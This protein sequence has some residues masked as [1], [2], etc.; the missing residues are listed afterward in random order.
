MILCKKRRLLQP[1]GN[2][3]D[4]KKKPEGYFTTGEFAKLCKVKKQTLFHYDHIGILK[5]ELIGENGY[6]YYSI[7][8]FD[9]YNTIAMLKELDMPLSRIRDFL[10]SRSPASFLS[11]L[12]AQDRLIDEKIAELQWLRSFV[13]G[14]EKITEEG[15]SA[16]HGEIRL[17]HRPKEYYIFTKYS[18]S[19]DDVD[20]Y[21]A[22]ADHVAHCHQNQIY[23]P[24]LTGGL[25]DA[26]GG[27]DD[28]DY[29]YSYLYTKLNPEDM[30]Y[31]TAS[32]T[33]IPPRTY[34]VIYST[35]GFEPVRS[36]FDALISFASAN[37]YTPGDFFF[38]DVLLDSVSRRTLDE[39]TVKLGLPVVK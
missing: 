33:A 20:E 35:N 26:K 29:R 23:S 11:L 22:F 14:K 4:I 9:T 27:Y 13:K 17:E 18:G 15:M 6:R 21:A 39:Y 1:G 3:M 37:G 32:I 38:E 7:F 10:S 25:I 36:M 8:Q 24:Y 34:A 16:G 31:A 28:V 19:A 5:P 30:D 2:M 12:K